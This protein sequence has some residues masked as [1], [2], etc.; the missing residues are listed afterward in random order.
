MAIDSIKTAGSTLKNIQTAIDVVANNIANINT[1]GFK[2]KSASF[3]SV[4]SRMG[5][6]TVMSGSVVGAINT[7]FKQGPLR[8]TNS[9]LDLA[10]SGNGFFAVENGAG[11]VRYTRSGSFGF[12]AEHN[13]VDTNGNYLMSIGASRITI[14]NDVTDVAINANGEVMIKRGEGA[15]ASFGLLD[16]I[17]LAN[18]SNPAGLESMGQNLYRESVNSGQVEF[19]TAL[20]IGTSLAAT[21]M[22]A[23]SLE[24]A[25]VDMSTSLV[26]LIALQRSYQ[27]MSKAADADN[28]ITQTTIGLAS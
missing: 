17:Q 20:G 13:L 25:N 4:I 24:Q 16:Q 26:E 23:G 2:T 18:F 7:N 1:Q 19:G 5:G 21:T 11:D 12:D 6:Q 9:A 14:P 28:Q 3:E 10:L 22:V 8:A 15:D 27:A